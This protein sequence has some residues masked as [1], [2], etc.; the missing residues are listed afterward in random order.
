MSKITAVLDKIEAEQRQ[1][2]TDQISDNIPLPELAEQVVRGKVKLTP[3]RH[4]RGRLPSAPSGAS[5]SAR[6]PLPAALGLGVV[7]DLQRRSTLSRPPQIGPCVHT[8]RGDDLIA[9]VGMGKKSGAEARKCKRPPGE[10][11]SF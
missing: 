3:P 8:I 10:A 4:R 1:Q 9:S 11:A 6:P 7:A 5:S 2:A